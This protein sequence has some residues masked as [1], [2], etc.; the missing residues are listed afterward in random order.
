MC[1][2]LLRWMILLFN[3]VFLV[4]WCISVVNFFGWLSCGGNGMFL[5]SVFCMFCGMLVI[6]G[7]V[8]ML[9]VIVMM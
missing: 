9:G 5:L 4:M 2:V 8:K 6:I 7:V 3:I 1:N